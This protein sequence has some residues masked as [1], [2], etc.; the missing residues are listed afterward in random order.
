MECYRYWPKDN[1]LN[2]TSKREF[3]EVLHLR[4]SWGNWE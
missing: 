1:E 4:L 3:D 2:E